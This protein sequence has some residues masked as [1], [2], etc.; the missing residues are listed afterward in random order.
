MARGLLVDITKM[1]IPIAVEFLDPI[2]PQY[3]A[4]L[5]SWG[6]IGART[7]ESQI[8]RQLASGLSM[9]IGFKN[10]TSG[11]WVK[12]VDAVLAAQDSHAFLGTDETTGRVAHVETT[13]N[14]DGHVVLRGGE[15][16]G[17]YR[18]SDVSALAAALKKEA[19]GHG[20]MIDC[21][22]ANS[23]KN[24]LRQVLVAL[25]ANR[26]RLSGL[27]VR[28]LM[29]ES[30]LNAGA[31]KLQPNL[32]HG[33][34]ITDACISWKSSVALLNVL[35]T[36]TL[37]PLEAV[38]SLDRLREILRAYDELIQKALETHDESEP[39]SAVPIALTTPEH[40]HVCLDKEIHQVSMAF[41]PS[42]Q[43]ERV[44]M[45]LSQRLA[46]SEQ[47]A[48]VKFRGKPFEYLRVS[49]DLW[50]LVTALPVE[51]DLLEKHSGNG[52]VHGAFLKILELSKMAQVEML[53]ALTARQ[54][55]GY[56]YGIGS[57]VHDVLTKSLR[58]QRVAFS[59]Q[60]EFYS[61]LVVGTIEFGCLPI[62]NSIAGRM[63]V[64]RDGF[65]EVGTIVQEI[66]LMLV[67]NQSSQQRGGV[68]Y[69]A[70]SL[71]AQVTSYLKANRMLFDRVENVATTVEGVHKTALASQP[72]FTFSTH[73][74]HLVVIETN[75]TPNNVTTFA[76]IAAQ[77]K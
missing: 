61:A 14:P 67:S 42:A 46:C 19:I 25:Y 56:P 3:L 39:F 28:A 77:K 30:N 52:K 24:H 34:S 9:P 17:N 16:E 63:E 40:H 51:L 41:A 50:Q 26:L 57:I 6:A 10:L 72:S 12:A 59:T 27:P 38:N 20:I 4:D 23:N 70:E 55:V 53:G 29:I 60:D 35:D 45:L 71:T 22:H 7:T 74:N 8:H 49:N 66:R 31:Q 32:Q 37:R 73:S 44:S 75:V 21:S 65:V 64:V 43:I 54:R 58:G 1:R 33:V 5:V 48:L 11:N 18:H 2:S 76:I 62:H 15:E 36:M 13:G 47:V 69:L 68:L